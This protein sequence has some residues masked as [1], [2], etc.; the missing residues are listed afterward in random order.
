MYKNC[1]VCSLAATILFIAVIAVVSLHGSSNRIF[2]SG[3]ETL[4]VDMPQKAYAIWQ[5]KRVKGRILLLFDNYPHMMG[6]FNY[7]GEPQ[8]GESNL[9]EYS[10]FKN[11]I[12]K[13]YF[14]I[15]DDAWED[16]LR[17]K[18]T[19]PIKTIAEMERG[20]FLYNLNGLPIIATTPSSLPHI[21]EEALVYINN[22]VFDA[23]QTRQLLA[24]KKIATDITVIYKAGSK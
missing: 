4:I 22:S 5:E 2:T 10:I 3:K 19:K 17:Q 9:I 16:F 14:I 1:I 21:S 8:L 23:G 12:R 11:V 24:Q 13:I 18:T 7:A 15:P 6:R 20:I